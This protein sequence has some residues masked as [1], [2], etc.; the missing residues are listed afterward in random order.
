MQKTTSKP[1]Q[2]ALDILGGVLLLALLYAIGTCVTDQAHADDGQRSVASPAPMT[3]VDTATLT[4][5]PTSVSP[6]WTEQ[7]ILLARL[8][9]NEANGREADTIAITL[10]RRTRTPDELRQMHPRALNPERTDGRRWIA[11][12]DAHM[13]EP[14]GWPAD[15]MPWSRGERIWMRTLVTVRETLRGEHACSGGVVPSIWGGRRLDSRHIERRLEQGFTVVECG[16]T[17]NMFL[18]RGR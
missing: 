16:A 7:E 13:G 2:Y 3:T 17:A 5:G 11:G 9:I 1:V 4:P 8:A 18:R 6:T 10:A 14:A 12:L 15:A